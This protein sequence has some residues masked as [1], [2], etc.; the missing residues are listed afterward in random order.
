[1]LQKL[2]QWIRTFDSTLSYSEGPWVFHQFHSPF[3]MRGEDYYP[4]GRFVFHRPTEQIAEIEK[5]LLS[6]IREGNINVFKY[7]KNPLPGE[8]GLAVVVYA[9]K[10]DRDLVQTSL[11]SLGITDYEWREGNPTPFYG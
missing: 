4:A 10:S 3:P 2:A 9:T 1:M 11:D 8:E 7:A 5:A 6:Q